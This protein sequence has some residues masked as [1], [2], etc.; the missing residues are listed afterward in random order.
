[1][2]AGVGSC[3]SSMAVYAL[4]SASVVPNVLSHPPNGNAHKGPSAAAS[5]EPAPATL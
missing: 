2:E 4:A 1:M 3:S 5:S